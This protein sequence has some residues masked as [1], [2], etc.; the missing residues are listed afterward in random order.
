MALQ[1]GGRRPTESSTNR[2]SL[3]ADISRF[4][5]AP[6]T[7]SSPFSEQSWDR[8]GRRE[9]WAA[10][11]EGGLVGPTSIATAAALVDKRTRGLRSTI[12]ADGERE[13]GKDEGVDYV[14]E[15]KELKWGERR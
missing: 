8:E 14:A 6:R 3:R 2:E 9:R 11:A 7:K 4:A 10:A 5:T 13:G 12:A 15:K 1:S